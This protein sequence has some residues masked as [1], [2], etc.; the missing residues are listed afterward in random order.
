MKVKRISPYSEIVK[1]HDYEWP[2]FRRS[3]WED[4][5][6]FVD[7]RW[8]EVYFPENLEKAYQQKKSEDDLIVTGDEMNFLIIDQKS[9]L[10]VM[11]ASDGRRL[12]IK[13][14][15]GIYRPSDYEADVVLEGPIGGAGSEGIARD[16]EVLFQGTQEECCKVLCSLAKKHFAA[17]EIHQSFGTPRPK[18]ECGEN[19]IREGEEFCQSC[20]G[21]KKKVTAIPRLDW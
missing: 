8:E 21:K 19:A 14:D 4:W 5:E 11:Q 15:I 6:Q 16:S 20:L 2:E 9:K 7:G 17:V 18:C 12:R 13:M 3:S 10:V 1:I